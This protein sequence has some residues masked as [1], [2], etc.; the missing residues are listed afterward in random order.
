M[1]DLGLKRISGYA[2][3]KRIYHTLLEFHCGCVLICSSYDNSIMRH[4]NMCS[5]L[6]HVV[7][8]IDYPIGE[9]LFI[10]GRRIEE[11]ARI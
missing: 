8:D 7:D 2:L 10:K 4:K 6:T 11:V 9:G 5:D 3:T 1:V